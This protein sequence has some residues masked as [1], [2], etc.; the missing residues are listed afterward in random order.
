MLTWNGETHPKVF[1]FISVQFFPSTVLYQN[2]TLRMSLAVKHLHMPHSNTPLWLNRGVETIVKHLVLRMG[3][4]IDYTF[5]RSTAPL[6]E[7]PRSHNVC[8]FNVNIG[9]ITIAS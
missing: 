3:I 4:I 7:L 6:I 8:L 2:K 9:S 1:F 5:S